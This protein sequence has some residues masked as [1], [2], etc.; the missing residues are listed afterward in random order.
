MELR[1]CP[2]TSADVEVT[3]ECLDDHVLELEGFGKQ[4]PVQEG[5]DSV[6]LK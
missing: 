5:M 4:F 2:A 1:L 6:L 3:Q